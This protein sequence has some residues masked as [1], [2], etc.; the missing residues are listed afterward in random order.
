MNILPGSLEKFKFLLRILNKMKNN[1]EFML[2]LYFKFKIKKYLG[3]NHREVNH[4]EIIEQKTN[5]NEILFI[6]IVKNPYSFFK[7]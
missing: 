4:F 7:M 2:D 1:Q 6:V 5:I 3:W